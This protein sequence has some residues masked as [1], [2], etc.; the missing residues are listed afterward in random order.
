MGWLA[1]VWHRPAKPEISWTFKLFAPGAGNDTCSAFRGRRPPLI[2]VDGAAD[3][4]PLVVVL[5]L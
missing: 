1:S 3:A 5:L 4:V 2:S